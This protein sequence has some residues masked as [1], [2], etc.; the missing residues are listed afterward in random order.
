MAT[1]PILSSVNAVIEIQD[2]IGSSVRSILDVTTGIKPALGGFTKSFGAITRAYRISPRTNKPVPRPVK[3]EPPEAITAEMTTKFSAVNYMEK[4]DEDSRFSL[5][6]RFPEKHPSNPLDYSRVDILTDVALE[7]I[8]WSDLVADEPTTDDITLTVPINAA[9]HTLIH[10][11]EGAKLATG[12][13]QAN[14][15]AMRC[16]AVDEDGTIYVGT[17]ADAVGTH[18]FL[19][20][21]ADDGGTWT[22]IELTDL[23]ADVVSLTIAGDY[24]VL[25]AGNDIHV[26]S[27]SGVKQSTYAAGGAVNAVAAADAAT[28]IACGAAGLLVRSVDGGNTW[29]AL[30]SGTAENLTAL[31]VRHIADWFVGGANG[32]LRH[33]Q[34]GAIAAVSLPAGLA[35][36]TV[37]A[38]AIPDSPAGFPRDEDVYIGMGDGT[39]WR[40]G[41]DG[42]AWEALSFPGSGAGSIT[43]LG[44]TAFLGQVFYF[45]HTLAGGASLLYRDFAGGAGGNNNVEL[46][47]IPTN[48][49]FN[50]LVIQDANNAYLFGEVHAASDLIVKVED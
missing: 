41:D 14:D 3:R 21:T 16:A 38:I 2:Q 20:V 35:A 24:L 22:E 43:T 36:V 34:D 7:S 18:P 1:D 29:S 8:Q 11:I 39:I 33:Y 40:T 30:T 32:T 19:I 15:C 48:S 9:A 50:A 37:N 23:T 31:A 49:G 45:V 17:E 46:I 6:V 44:F 42:G 4:F 25:A 26:Y 27:K 13:A 10:K 12:L 47:S 5:Y 28:I